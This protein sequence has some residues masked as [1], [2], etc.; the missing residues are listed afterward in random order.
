MKKIKVIIVDDS[1]LITRI[2]SEILSQ[3]PNIDVVGIAYDPYEAREKIRQL[4]PDV[5]TLDVEM[6]KMDGITF[7]KNIMRLRPLP[8]V[9]ISTLTQSGAGITLEALEIGA[10]DFIPKPKSMP[11]ERLGAM[12]ATICLKIKQA[13]RVN[14]AIFENYIDAEPVKRAVI[15][16]SS[17]KSGHIKLIVI[18][19]STGG[20][21]ALKQVFTALPKGMP[22]IAVVQHMPEGFTASFAQRLDNCCELSVEEFSEDGCDLEPDHIYIARGNQHFTVKNI[23]GRL[24]GSAVDTEPVN[25]HKPSVDVLFDSVASWC[26]DQ[27]IGVILTGMGADGA[28][29]ML[30][31]KKKGVMTIAQDEASSVVWGMPRVAVENDAVDYVLPLNKIAQFLVDRCA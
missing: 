16:G 27:V 15:K 13:A 8:V 30:R 29:G 19:A 6:P 1:Q 31:L 4:N 7:L 26:N 24:K 12:A 20:T 5:I 21:L 25:R 9:M 3:D 22:P 2:L 11:G 14:S 18:G 10:V 17:N 23:A 28:M